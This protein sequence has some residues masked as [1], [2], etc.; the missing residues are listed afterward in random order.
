MADLQGWSRG[1]WGEGDWGEFIPVS[2]TGEQ[3]NTAIGTLTI[4]ADAVAQP[5]GVSSGAVLG[6]AIG[7]PESIYPVTGVQANTETGTLEA[8]EGHGVQPTGVSMQFDDGTATAKG[9]VDAGW[10]RDAWGSLAWGQNFVDANVDVTGIEST[11]ETGTLEGL[12]NS[13]VPVTGLSTSVD[14]GVYDVTATANHNP[15]GVYAQVYIER[16]DVVGDALVIPTGVSA[17][18]TE[19]TEVISGDAT[20]PVTGV[21]AE[22]VVGTGTEIVASHIEEVTGVEV[23]TTLGTAEQNSVYPVTGLEMQFDD[24]TAAG[25]GNATVPVSGIEMSAVLGNMRSTPW[26]NVVTGASNTWTSVAA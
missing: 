9:S 16:P 24:G 14:I 10:G 3:S 4:T 26:A 7:E 11:F 18:F 25:V 2:V 12:G 17:G 15:V 8:Q 1:T 23:S 13:V 21:T 6:T 5:T 19:G 20:V 22:S